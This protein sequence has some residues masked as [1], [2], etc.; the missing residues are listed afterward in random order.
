M[1]SPKPSLTHLRCQFKLLQQ[2]LFTTIIIF[3][4]LSSNKGKNVQG[5][6]SETVVEA[7]TLPW[8]LFP[9]YSIHSPFQKHAGTHLCHLPPLSKQII[10]GLYHPL[11]QVPGGLLHLL[12]SCSTGV[13]Y[14]QLIL[15]LPVLLSLLMLSRALLVLGLI[16]FLF[17][18]I[19]MLE[20]PVFSL[21]LVL[22]LPVCSLLLPTCKLLCFQTHSVPLQL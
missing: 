3:I 8:S 12:H 20:S 7:D 9:P 6:L 2:S 1:N 18:L 16:L 21:A 14:L 19:L 13:V 10:W 5:L 15:M 17:S 11:G 4:V 22:L